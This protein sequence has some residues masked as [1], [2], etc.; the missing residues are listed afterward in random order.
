LA[1][2]DAR[3][4]GVVR[5]DDFARFYEPNVE[6]D[7]GRTFDARELERG[8]GVLGRSVARAAMAEHQR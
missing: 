4:L 5:D 3:E 8:E 6:L 7:P 2:G 1:A